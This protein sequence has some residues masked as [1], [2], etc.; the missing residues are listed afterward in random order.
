MSRDVSLT[1]AWRRWVAENMLLGVPAADIERAAAS[2]GIERETIRTEIAMAAGDPYV[3]AGHWVADRLRKL[4]SVLQVRVE[5]ARQNDAMPAVECCTRLPA[6]EFRR[7]FYAR[8]R[9]V[10]LLGMIDHWAAT[11]KWSPSYFR[12]RYGGAH[13][14]V[15][16][17]RNADPHYEINLEQHRRAM[18]M[19]DFAALID[20]GEGND[21][22]LVA[23][24][25][26]FE[27]AGLTKLLD[28]VGPL[29]GYLKAR[30]PSRTYLWLGPAGT[31]TPLHHD[32]VN[33]LFCQIHGRKRV[34][35]IDPNETPWLYN[36]VAVYSD[37]AVEAPD[38][39]RHPLFRLAS[40]L[41]VVVNPGEILFIPV[42]WWHHV[43][44]LDPSISVSFTNF[45]FPNEYRWR[46]P[47]IRRDG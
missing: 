43:R 30:D 10:K 36:D 27:N 31:V 24:N 1:P 32:T 9:P 34:L 4:E 33:V 47:D 25:H 28:D 14:E 2:A 13:V 15:C 42:G 16:A 7:R 37:V 21:T 19:G 18:L 22:Y 8:N 26:A 44:S 38:F 29:P 20:A 17:G 23:N 46:Q 6:S 45:D 35:L 3:E 40:P 5:V 41:E 39:A 12:D 11:W